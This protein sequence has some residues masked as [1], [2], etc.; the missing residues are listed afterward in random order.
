M[1]FTAQRD[2]L[3]KALDQLKP[4]IAARAALPV[5]QGVLIRVTGPNT[6]TFEGTNLEAG[7]M[8]EVRVA[9]VKAERG[10]R[11]VV[12]HRQLNET[13]KGV[14]PQAEVTVS[15]TE[16]DHR[17]AISD[18]AGVYQVERL[19]EQ[20]YPATTA[21]LGPKAVTLTGDIEGLFDMIPR[22][23]V[24]ASRDQAREIL[25]GVLIEAHDGKTDVVATDSWRLAF[26]SVA[27]NGQKGSILLPAVP[28]TRI[29]TGL[30]PQ[31]MVID[32]RY[33]FFG[34]A[35]LAAWLRAIE[36]SFPNWRRLTDI[37]GK[38]A[39]G[40][41]FST[42]ELAPQL[43]AAKTLSE[44]HVPIR[45]DFAA[46]RARVT[47]QD[48]GEFDQP[49]VGRWATAPRKDA[50]TVAWNTAYL[51]AITK[52]FGKAAKVKA[53]IIDGLKPA[54]FNS[55]DLNYLLMPVRI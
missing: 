19:N 30:H 34:G 21:S 53:G 22:V 49:I 23:A 48:V 7:A 47:R 55:G 17:V 6:L 52:V 37:E 16:S 13:L 36:G 12:N 15:T 10:E 5:L 2:A 11:L 32:E 42:D 54:I 43:A 51:A 3:T 8:V 24:A 50:V 20:D 26:G 33:A 38:V 45:Y 44:D 39:V 31:V 1:R 29:I 41:E 28:L 9:Q 18:T 4:F 27:V 25:Q 35:G 46:G 40:W 14:R